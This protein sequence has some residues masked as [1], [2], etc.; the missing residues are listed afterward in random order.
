MGVRETTP[1]FFF[2]FLREIVF[3]EDMQKT[4]RR[5]WNE[6]SKLPLI[7]PAGSPYL[8]RKEKQKNR[9]LQNEKRKKGKRKRFD[10][11]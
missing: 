8:P 5:G 9:R 3:V 4:A 7:S 10:P 11:I 6:W 1:L 2:F